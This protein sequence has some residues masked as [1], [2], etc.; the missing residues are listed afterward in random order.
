[1]ITMEALKDI[2][3]ILLFLIS[4]A[5]W[6]SNTKKNSETEVKR[7][8][9]LESKID[10]LC[11]EVND[12]KVIKDD[13]NTLDRRVTRLESSIYKQTMRLDK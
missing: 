1:M 12:L 7:F 13:V 8:Y 6:W 10:R 9:K 2:I 5:G 4:V 3:T 11:S